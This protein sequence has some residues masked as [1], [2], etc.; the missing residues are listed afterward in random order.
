MLGVLQQGFVGSS[1]GFVAAV[2]QRYLNIQ[3]KTLSLQPKLLHRLHF[4]SGLG[5]TQ[6]AVGGFSQFHLYNCRNLNERQTYGYLPARR[7]HP[8]D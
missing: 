1:G 4:V 6:C 5:F 3:S 7:P 2:L 8:S